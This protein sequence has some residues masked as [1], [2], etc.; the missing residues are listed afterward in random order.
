MFKESDTCKVVFKENLVSLLKSCSLWVFAI[1]SS[2]FIFS[3][4]FESQTLQSSKL[5]Q[6]LYKAHTDKK[7]EQVCHIHACI[8]TYNRLHVFSH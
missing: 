8:H 5:I 6:M 7:K 1:R 4:S 3:E 2:V